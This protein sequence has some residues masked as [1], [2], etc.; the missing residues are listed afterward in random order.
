MQQAAAPPC[1]FSITPTS[2]DVD[3]NGGT[4]P[5]AVTAGPGCAWTSSSS[6]PWIA[7]ALGAGNGN[8][9]VQLSVGRNE[10]AARTGTATIAGQA[11]TV[12]QGGACSFTIS[13][14]EQNVERT[15]GTAVVSV[16][17]QVG[18]GW[19][20]ATTEPWITVP[21]G[22]GGNGNGS[23]QLTVN[24]NDGAARTGVATIAGHAFTV[25][26]SG[27]CSFA[28]APAAADAGQAG[29]NLT[30]A[31]TADPGCGWTAST[32]APWI[33][34]P[35]GAAGT[36]GG[37][38]QISVAANAGPARE[39]I[40]TIAGHPFTVRQA[41]ACSFTI[42]PA[43]ADIA[44]TGGTAT[45]NVTAESGCAWAAS[46]TTPWIAITSGATGNGAG[47]VQL[48]IVPNDAAAREGVVT[49]AGHAFIVRQAGACSFTVAPESA[50]VP[51]AGLDLS[52]TVGTAADCDWIA[53]TD[54]AWVQILSGSPGRGNGAVQLRALPND[55]AART[56][57][58][59]I[60]GRTV[61]LSQ[62]SGC[63]IR[64]STAAFE[65]DEDGG[66]RSIDVTAGLGCG[67]TTASQVPWIAITAGATGSSNGRVT[68]TVE[69]NRGDRRTGTI[70]IGTQ[71]VVVNQE[72]DDEEGGGNQR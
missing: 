45:V 67:W 13:P 40:A 32:T 31:V 52:V 69:R 2:Q 37:S 33:S 56:G 34:F 22:A 41:G 55:G 7:I 12:R 58:V 19:T 28:I 71:T 54:A 35:A 5:V 25:R 64:L 8:G 3:R 63:T 59:V 70:T 24:A 23:V 62:E 26:Q 14:T 48:S 20:A 72:E 57:N 61:V 42:A 68:F 60:G 17:T 38:I 46:T 15:G 11:F 9:S 18:C 44:R 51:A 47:S 4:V 29:A 1:S 50:P 10:G 21:Q 6:A 53:T 49:I 66:E 16:T 39:A 65:I 43:S 30:V 27:A 36:G